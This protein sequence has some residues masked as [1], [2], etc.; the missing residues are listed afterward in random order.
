MGI[1]RTERKEWARETL[2]GV[3]N[4]TM[5][6]FTS[7]FRD[8]DEAGIRWDVNQAVEHGFFSTMCAVEAGLTT[9]EAKRFLRT[10]ADEAAGRI[11][12]SLALLNDSFEQ[13]VELLS[14]AE[15]VG[16]SHALLG[17]PQTF[18]PAGGTDIYAA[19]AALS[20]ATN[21]G[22]V[23]YVTNKFDFTR[24]HPSHID[25]DAYDRIAD[26]PNVVGMKIGF[27]DP[28]VVF[29]CL[30]RYGNRV[31]VNVGTPWLMGLFPL[32]WREYGVQWFGGGLWEFWQSPG[33][34]NVI[35]Y[36][37]LVTDGRTEEA[38]KLY[39]SL[40]PAT[41]L[42][43]QEGVGRGG[44]YGMYHWPMG[45]YVSWTVGGNGGLIRE[46]AMRL[47]PGQMEMRKNALRA[48]GIEPRQPDDEF[49]V[50]RVNYQ[51]E[52]SGPSYRP[53]APAGY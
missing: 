41:S 39:F 45:K 2:R 27:G 20:E 16:C 26:L 18:R 42:A 48:I 40:A 52:A 28:A 50:G 32:L 24:F 1:S 6:S 38:L 13:S 9:E 17:Y 15:A 14:Y 23:M 43:M 22:L 36:Y 3:E 21:L 11:L 33:K 44:D 35:E 31:L 46:P 53:K 51:G 30:R 34:P 8:L 29:E 49:F 37:Q 5:P 4:V 7:D 10:V 25:F 19:T 47:T 12:V